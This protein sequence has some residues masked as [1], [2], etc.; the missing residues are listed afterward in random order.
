[1]QLSTY[2]LLLNILSQKFHQNSVCSSSI[3][4]FTPIFQCQCLVT[5][6]THRPINFHGVLAASSESS[7]SDLTL[8]VLSSCCSSR[9]NLRSLLTSMAFSELSFIL[10]TQNFQIFILSCFFPYVHYP[11]LC[12]SLLSQQHCLLCNFQPHLLRCIH[13][14]LIHTLHKC[15]YLLHLY[16]WIFCHNNLTW[17]QWALSR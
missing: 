13:D 17:A 2:L 10:W 8:Y 7:L 12:L 4:F 1:M 16:F 9:F 14:R 3:S 6:H 11:S 5:C 15:D